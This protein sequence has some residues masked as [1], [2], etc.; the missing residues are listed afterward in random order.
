MEVVGVVV[1]VDDVGWVC[2]VNKGVGD[3]GLW[4]CVI[5]VVVHGGI[6]SGEWKNKK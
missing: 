6:V 4:E 1:V 5:F 3:K 2:R